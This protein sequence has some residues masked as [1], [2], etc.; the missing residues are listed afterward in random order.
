MIEGGRAP[1]ECDIGQ[2]DVT[3]VR[4]EAS[5]RLRE[6]GCERARLR[7]LLGGQPMPP[8]IRYLQLQIAFAADALTT[9]SVIPADFRHDR[10]WPSLFSATGTDPIR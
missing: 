10:Y 2:P 9:L 1:A 4:A 6:S 7:A 8:S 5:R 3:A